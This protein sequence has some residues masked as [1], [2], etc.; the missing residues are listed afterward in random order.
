MAH[1]GPG[2]FTALVPQ[3]PPAKARSPFGAFDPASHVRVEPSSP[4]STPT[5]PDM[6][7]PPAPPP[8]SWGS[9][10]PATTKHEP[11]VKQPPPGH[12]TMGFP[13]P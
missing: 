6:E 3:A 7:P 5:T 10:L 13:H 12:P 2:A 11:P 1:P 9:P 4:S 8:Q